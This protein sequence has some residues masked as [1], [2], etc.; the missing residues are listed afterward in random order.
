M[1]AQGYALPTK[2]T[3]LSTTIVHDLL[4]ADDYA[5]NITT[6]VGVQRSIDLF[7]AG[8]AN[9][10]LTTSTDK[11]VVIQQQSPNT[12]HCAPPQITFDG[13]KLKTVDNFV[14][15]GSTFPNNTRI[16][17]EVAHRIAKASQAF[18]RQQNSVRNRYGLQVNAELRVK[19]GRCLTKFLYGAE[20]W[21]V[22]SSHA[23]KLNHVH[24]SCLRRIPK[25]KWQDRI[26]DTNF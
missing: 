17:D 19:Q 25:L 24:L 21:T 12:Q 5:R 13:K 11:T 23:K 26:S 9:F 8:C 10:V 14:Y 7:A 3:R 2:L 1:S 4:F 16:D 6:E 22:Y 20:T 18:G 15:L